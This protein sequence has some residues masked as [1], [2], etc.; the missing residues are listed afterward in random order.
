MSKTNPCIDC[1]RRE[2]KT[3]LVLLS[4]GDKVC[5]YCDLWKIEC[6]AKHLLAMPLTQRR[7]E[8]D[9]RVKRRG[10]QSV[11]ELK[12]VMLRIHDKRLLLRNSKQR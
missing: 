11:D 10:K 5:T 8:L 3:N 2:E 4:S 12:A 1:T 9:E 7:Q 6:E